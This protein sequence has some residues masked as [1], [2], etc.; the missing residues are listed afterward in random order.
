MTLAP[1]ATRRTNRSDEESDPAV[2]A[3][4]VI[5][6]GSRDI[7]CVRS[8]RGSLTCCA[9]ANPQQASPAGW[10]P[11][12]HDCEPLNA[13]D[14]N[15]YKSLVDVLR[16]GRLTF[17]YTVTQVIHVETDAPRM[18]QPHSLAG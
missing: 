1:R 4:L 13:I 6:C 3:A 9:L 18:S 10:A 16:Y 8:L 5:A 12:I 2:L 15:G 17:L 11:C 14:P 7:D